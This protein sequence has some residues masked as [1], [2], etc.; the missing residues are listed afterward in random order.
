MLMYTLR[1]RQLDAPLLKMSMATESAGPQKPS[2]PYL[3]FPFGMF[4]S[5]RAHYNFTFCTLDL[6]E[7]N[8]LL[9]NGFHG[10]QN[11]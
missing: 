6:T 10:T 11:K 7:P 5:P 2:N 8:E 3:L 4:G 9:Y 1:N